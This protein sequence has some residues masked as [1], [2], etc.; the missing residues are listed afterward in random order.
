MLE[1]PADGRDGLSVW[2]FVSADGDHQAD[3]SLGMHTRCVAGSLQMSLY[4]PFWMINRT[5]KMLTYKVR[6][7]G[8]PRARRSLN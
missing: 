8:R 4:A 2:S 5:G 6:S 1:T 3:L 7:A